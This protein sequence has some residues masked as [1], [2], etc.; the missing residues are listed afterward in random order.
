[1]ITTYNATCHKGYLGDFATEWW[2]DD[3]WRKHKEYVEELIKDG[4][5][6]EEFEV[7]LTLQHLPGWDTPI[8]HKSPIESYRMII[9][10]F[11]NDNSN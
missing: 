1:M 7:E 8:K 2:T 5:Y 11:S 3:D 6:G 9:I 4:T 10:D